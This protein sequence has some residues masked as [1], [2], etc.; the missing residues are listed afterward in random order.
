MEVINVD[1]KGDA[2]I[3]LEK[4]EKVKFLLEAQ[5]KPKTFNEKFD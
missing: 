1:T 5:S 4:H 2:N 3:D